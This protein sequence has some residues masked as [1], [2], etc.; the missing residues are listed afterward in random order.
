MS[1]SKFIRLVGLG[2]TCLAGIASLIDG[3]ARERRMEEEVKNA[4]DKAI[5]ERENTNSDEG[6]S[7]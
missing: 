5:A 4:V 2:A 1:S 3:W 7:V 6:E